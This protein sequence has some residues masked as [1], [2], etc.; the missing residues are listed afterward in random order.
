MKTGNE[1]WNELF[2]GELNEKEM[3]LVRG[4]DGPGEDPSQPIIKGE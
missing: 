1:N 3:L 4:G 2:T